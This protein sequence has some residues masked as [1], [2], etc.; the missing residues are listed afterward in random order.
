MRP[1]RRLGVAAAALLLLGGVVGSRGGALTPPPGPDEAPEVAHRAGA[2]H[3]SSARTATERRSETITTSTGEQVRLEVSEAY[4]SDPAFSQAWGEFFA[5]LVHGTELGQVTIR[6]VAPAELA[7][8][9]GPRALGCY[10]SGLIVIPGEQAGGV[11]AAEIARHEYGHHVAAS[12][13][14]PPW[15]AM[16]WGTKRWATQAGICRRAASGEIA[17]DDYANYEL[18]PREAFAEVY[19]VLNDRRA[20]VTGITWSIVDDRF[21]PDDAALRA[22]EEDVTSPWGAATTTRFNGRFR[23]RGPRQWTRRIATPLDGTLTVAL[24][25]PRGRTDRVELLGI[26]GR[27]LARGLWSG[28]STKR[29]GFVVCGQRS[30]QVRVTLGGA[31]GPF[32]LAIARA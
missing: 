25:L 19:R 13:Q 8:S 16:T 30:F 15:N 31:A 12:R 26:D 6:I 32:G 27:V 29:L 20:G 4:G 24:R 1:Q 28:T 11:E 22:V 14:N 5:G 18:S 10:T 7:A 21:L 2:P 3:A 17:P 23:A 9:C